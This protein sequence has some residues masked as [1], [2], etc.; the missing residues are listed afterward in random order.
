[1]ADKDPAFLFYS[2][3]WIVGTTTMSFED[4]GKYITI[5]ALMHQNGGILDTETIRLL[6]GSV[7]VTL[8]KKFIVD[9]DGFWHNGRLDKEIENRKNFVESRQKNGK[10]GGRPPMKKKKITDRI[11][12]GKPT[13]N[14]P[15]DIDKSIDL[16][17]ILSL[18]KVREN[19]FNDYNLEVDAR[20]ESGFTETEFE[21][22]RTEFWNTK[23]LDPE[24]TA[25]P[26]SATQR[27][28][29]NWCRQNKLRIKETKNG[30]RKTGHDI[31][32]S[33]DLADRILSGELVPNDRPSNK[34]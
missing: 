1:M 8:Q 10:L 18:E 11:P 29:L 7:S 33:L 27:H 15:L 13:D 9:A 34:A 22:A 23:K 21:Q 6:V 14:L 24:T 28:F 25:M 31:E 32:K 4:R 3:K 19:F 2:E 20:K 12:V 16:D 17:L 30:T 26:Y 5:L